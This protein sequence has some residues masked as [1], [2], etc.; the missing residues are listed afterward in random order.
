M[1]TGAF[2]PYAKRLN[3]DYLGG[4]VPCFSPIYAATEGLVGINLSPAKRPPAYSLIPKALFYEF[5]PVE[6]AE[7]EE[8]SSPPLG[9]TLLANN[10]AV[11]EKYELVITNLAGLVRYRMG[12]VVK[13]ERYEGTALFASLRAKV[14]SYGHMCD[15]IDRTESSY[16]LIIKDKTVVGFSKHMYDVINVVVPVGVEN[17]GAR[18]FSG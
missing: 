18:A 15:V 4:A 12:D 17:I 11:G 10:L 9:G 3:T 5:I 8:N 14:T 7:T 1:T 13:L 16:G 2:L 6:G